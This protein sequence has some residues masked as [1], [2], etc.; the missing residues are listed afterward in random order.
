MELLI[1]QQVAMFFLCFGQG[2]VRKIIGRNQSDN[3]PK[4]LAAIQ[5]MVES[6]NGY[7]G[8]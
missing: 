6:Y 5:T 2:L 3:M 4:K 8:L 1:L 7:F